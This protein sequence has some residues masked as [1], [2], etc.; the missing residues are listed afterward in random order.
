VRLEWADGEWRPAAV[1]DPLYLV[2]VASAG[3]LPAVPAESTLADYRLELI[4]EAERR[5]AE[6]QREY[7]SER[8]RLIAEVMERAREREEAN[9]RAET[10]EV[11]LRE[12]QASVTWQL[13]ERARGVLYRFIRRDSVIGRTLSALLR[14]IGGR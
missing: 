1:P 3:A 8:E 14:R 6:L 9:A 10:V 12:L 2:A 13:L 4:A 5:R 11:A 7:L